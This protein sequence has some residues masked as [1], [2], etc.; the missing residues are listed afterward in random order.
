MEYASQRIK[1][2]SDKL[3]AERTASDPKPEEGKELTE[4][5]ERDIASRRQENNMK[6]LKEVERLI[7][8]APKFKFNTNVFKKNVQLDMSAEEIRGE[9]KNVESLSKF[10][11]EK[12]IPNLVQDLKQQEGIP[13]DS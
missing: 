8:E 5:Q 13:I 1:E 4:D 6:K 10:I 9:E 3:D 12:A 11:T 7:A 2:F